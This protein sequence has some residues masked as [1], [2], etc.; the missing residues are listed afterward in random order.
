VQLLRGSDREKDQS[1]FLHALPGV[2]LAKT[3]LPLAALRKDEVRALARGAGL[4][5]HDKEDSTGICFIGERRFRD[6][7]ARYLPP[8]PGEIRDLAGRVLGRHAG[9]MYYTL[10]QRH[11]LGL[12]GTG[13]PWYVAA[14]NL[15]EN[16]LY[17]VQ[18]HDHP[19]LFSRTLDAAELSWVS[20]TPPP[21]PFACTA[22]TRYRQ[23]D[24]SC[25]IEEIR[26]GMARVVFGQAQRAVTPGQYVVFYRDDVCLGGGSI[27][28]SDAPA[29]ALARQ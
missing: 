26:D 9:L 14:K 15:R 1:Y 17:V 24:Q 28:G 18:G 20:G 7:L 4:P 19:A 27:Q 8:S 25:V 11:G 10:G 3:L 29:T 6:F 16:A 2:A 5:V 23:P 22:K 13:E 21:T 12:G